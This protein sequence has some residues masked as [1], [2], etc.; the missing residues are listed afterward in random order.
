MDCKIIFII[1]HTQFK[2]SKHWRK[3]LSLEVKFNSDIEYDDAILAL[4]DFDISEIEFNG[5]HVEKN[6]LGYYVDFSITKVNVGKI[7][8]GENTIV[9]KKPFNVIS[10]VENMFLL[11]NFGVKVLGDTVNVDCAKNN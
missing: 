6:A 11:G 4:E 8:K 3:R 2:V 1:F 9:I 5:R 7:N 10:C